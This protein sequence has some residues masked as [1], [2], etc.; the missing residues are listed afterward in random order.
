[1]SSKHVRTTG[2]LVRFGLNAPPCP[3]RTGVEHH[4]DRAAS[5]GTS[6]IATP[7]NVRRFE[8]MP[9]DANYLRDRAKHLRK[10]AAAAR[11]AASV[12]HLIQLADD[13][14]AEARNIEDGKPNS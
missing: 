1:M 10:L 7:L 3:L 9:L 14:E 13:F 6:A 12:R 5:H 4:L 8:R 2:D 11:D